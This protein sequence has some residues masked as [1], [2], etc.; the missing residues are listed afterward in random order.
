ML[1]QASVIHIEAPTDFYVVSTN[2]Y[3]FYWVYVKVLADSF[4]T[5]SSYCFGTKWLATR[6][7]RICES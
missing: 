1:K 7:S 3:A 4:Q 6:L 2:I 5:S